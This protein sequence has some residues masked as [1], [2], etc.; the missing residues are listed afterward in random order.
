[1]CVWSSFSFKLTWE[2]VFLVIFWIF[3]FNF[4]DSLNIETS[5]IKLKPYKQI[6]RW[7]FLH[8]I[9]VLSEYTWMS[10]RSKPSVRFFIQNRFIFGFEIE[11]TKPPSHQ[12]WGDW[13][14]AAKPI[15]YYNCIQN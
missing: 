2:F 1:M 14:D 9:T 6:M 10:R 4:K 7:S 11:A 15:P 8:I 5:K 12:I 3:Y 13:P